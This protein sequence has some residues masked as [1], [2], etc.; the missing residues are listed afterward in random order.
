MNEKF[1]LTGGARI[2]KANATYPFADLYVDKSILKINASIVGDLVFQPKDIIE[3]KPY[4]SIPVIG[5]GIKVIHRVEKYNSEVIF[6]TLKDP[7]LVISEIEKTG[8]ME[9]T[10][11]D[12]IDTN[13]GMIARQNQGSFPMKKTAA[14]FFIAVWN[15]LILSAIIP[16]I[17]NSD[18]KGFPLGIGINL[19]LGFILVSSILALVSKSFRK[20]ILKE[21]RDFED[22]KKFIYLIIFITG[23]MSLTFI[24]GKF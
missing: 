13:L 9:N 6:W 2:G 20:L 7:K 15:L 18:S 3:L 24:T 23:I 17:L 19:A 11:T 8:F 14:I 21:G 5:N 22:I 16:S 4:T 10:D 1:T 12:L